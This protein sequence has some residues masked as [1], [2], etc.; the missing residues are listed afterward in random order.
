MTNFPAPLPAAG[1]WLLLAVPP[2]DQRSDCGISDI[3]LDTLVLNPKHLKVPVCL[4]DQESDKLFP[5]T[6]DLAD[7]S[8]R[9]HF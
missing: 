2:A 9:P 8:Q 3:K 5:N 7:H 4:I 1:W 6:L